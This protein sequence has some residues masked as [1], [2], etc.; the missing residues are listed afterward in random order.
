MDKWEHGRVINPG[1]I[2]KMHRDLDMTAAEIGKQVGLSTSNV[3]WI[4]AGL[5]A[6]EKGQPADAA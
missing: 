5:E 1:V 3:F 4:L 2:A 6:K